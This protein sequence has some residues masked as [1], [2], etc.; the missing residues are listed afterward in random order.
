[1]NAKYQEDIRRK[2]DDAVHS[3]YPTNC[4]GGA[5]GSLKEADENE[6]PRNTKASSK[7][8]GMVSGDGEGI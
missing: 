8:K 2:Y 4:V 1:M 7:W 5:A 3:Y 6:H